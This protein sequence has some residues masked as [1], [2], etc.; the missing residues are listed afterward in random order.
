MKWKR[1]GNHKMPLPRQEKEGDAGFDLRAVEDV[2]IL[3][4]QLV[5]V[6]T[7]FAPVFGHN[8]CGFV[9]PR[10]GLS[11]K[12][13]LTTDAGVIDNGFIGEIEVAL[14]NDGQEWQEIK[15][16]ERIAQMVVTM[17]LPSESEEVF[18]LPETERG[19][20]GWGSTGNG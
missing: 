2:K 8:L 5:S 16:G 10:S 9:W 14:R 6:R 11:V 1:I 15:A 20:N 13:R 18:E 3:P 19:A 12:R 17:F 4:G 7:G